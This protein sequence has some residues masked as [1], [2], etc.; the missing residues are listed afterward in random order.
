MITR[1][2]FVGQIIDELSEISNQVETRCHLN[3]TELNLHLENFFKELLNTVMGLEL[4]NLNGV[5]SNSPGIDLGDERNRIAFQI[6][7]TKSSEKI[8][9]TLAAISQEDK[10]KYDRVQVLIIGKKQKT[11]TLDESK[12]KEFN[13]SEDDILDT[14]D[15]CKHLMNLPLDGLQSAFEYVNAEV[16]RVKIELEIPTP[17]GKFATTIFDFVESIPIP[18]IGD[19]IAFVDNRKS[20]GDFFEVERTHVAKELEEFSS[21][22]SKLPRITREF[23]A[24][25]LERR[26]EGTDAPAR[27]SYDK[28]ERICKWKDIDGELRLLEAEGLVDVELPES[29]LMNSCVVKIH[30]RGE[31]YSRNYDDFHSDF[32][33]F[34]AS[35]SL[36]LRKVIGCLDFS[37]F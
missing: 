17:A 7:S 36:S 6:T 2:H 3:L 28:L 34:T 22:L 33:K 31:L 30:V 20:E 21:R 19:C 35:E 27:I 24:M 15:L 23:F 12:C 14:F 8:N 26:D 11:Y 10:D 25:L 4:V 1:G 18:K 29:G 9:K 16:A 13:F 32:L 5:R 37:E